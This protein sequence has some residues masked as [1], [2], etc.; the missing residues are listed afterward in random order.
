MYRL[1]Y[2]SLVKML[3]LCQF[4][5][6]LPILYWIDT[7]T[8]TSAFFICLRYVQHV[9]TLLDVSR[10]TLQRKT[11]EMR[12]RSTHKKDTN[13]SSEMGRALHKI[14]LFIATAKSQKSPWTSG[15]FF[16]LHIS[17]RAS[18]STAP[19]LVRIDETK[20]QHSSISLK[21]S[22]TVKQWRLVNLY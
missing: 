14:R 13:H 15:V 19:A 21:S 7:E 9:H 17:L 3:Q 1:H 22:A 4:Q 8:C 12:R 11:M 20:L 18:P 2:K 5:I 6:I 10:V 16:R